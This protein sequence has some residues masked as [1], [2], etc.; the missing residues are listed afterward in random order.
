MK[1][2]FIVYKTDNA[3]SLKSRDVLGVGTTR[4]QAYK[5]IKAQMKKENQK[6]EFEQEFNLNHSNQTQDYKGAGEFDIEEMET[7]KLY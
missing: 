7:N 5:L 3:H 4:A 1:S 6:L 2:I